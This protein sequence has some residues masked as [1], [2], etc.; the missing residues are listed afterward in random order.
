M[1]L[2]DYPSPGL[3]PSP[4]PAPPRPLP[5]LIVEDEPSSRTA[6]SRL[7]RQSGYAN[8]AVGSAEEALQLIRDSGVPRVALVDLN[9][10]GMSGLDLI[11][12]M[13]RIDPSV[14]SVLTTAS[15]GD[16]LL[17]RVSEYGVQYLR[18]PLDF[19]RLLGLLGGADVS[20]H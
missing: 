18:K 2:Q 20:R 14:R 17:E 1:L 19:N 6:L 12:R 3:M 4:P 16:A 11:D 5:V 13:S 9:L 15:G 7:L 8:R 10:P